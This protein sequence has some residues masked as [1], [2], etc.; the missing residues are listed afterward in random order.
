MFLVYNIFVWGLDDN[1][2]NTR[3]SAN[4]NRWKKMIKKVVA[5]IKEMKRIRDKY[6]IPLI[7][8]NDPKTVAFVESAAT[9]VAGQASERQLIAFRTPACTHGKCTMCGFGKE[10][11]QKVT[12]DE[13][14]A[15]LASF[16]MLDHGR[17]SLCTESSF[18]HPG[19][20][21]EFLEHVF[22]IIRARGIREIDLE[23]CATDVIKE[24]EQIKRLQAMLRSNQQL[25][26]GMGLESQDDFVRKGLIGK[27]L[28]K[29]LFEESVSL[30]AKAGVGVFAYIILKPPGL[31][32]K[33]AIEECIRTV[34]YFFRIVEQTGVEYSRAT[35]KP[36]FIPKGTIIE[37]LFEERLITTPKLWSLLRVL[38]NAH[39]LGTIFVP[40]TDENLS[41][42]RI[43][44][45][46]DEC[47]GEA[48]KAIERFNATQK[49]EQLLEL[50]CDCK[51]DW[52]Q[53]VGEE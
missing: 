27:Q 40:L 43:P 17:V 20:P 22:G 29:E 19:I 46:C 41:H 33:E 32:E 45:N 4:C 53:E 8:N 38:K 12:L 37:K 35:I 36:L 13:L 18:F 34:E 15:Q 21:K 42:G 9:V 44:E 3:I 1:N 52:V 47:S 48:R 7:S 25:Y 50:S 26:V 23:A 2:L 5:R 31:E 14:K 24:I 6:R 49:I 16:E 28:P 30:L 39:K 51:K 10:A 11:V